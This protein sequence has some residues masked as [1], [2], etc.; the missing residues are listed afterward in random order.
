M[1]DLSLFRRFSFH[2]FCIFYCV[3]IV[4]VFLLC[5]F[6]D[7]HIIQQRNI[8]SFASFNTFSNWL[9]VYMFVCLFVCCVGGCHTG[10]FTGAC[11]CIL[12]ICVLVLQLTSASHCWNSGRDGMSNFPI[13][14]WTTAPLHHCVVLKE[15]WH[16]PDHSWAVLQLQLHQKISCSCWCW[17]EAAWRRSH[18]LEAAFSLH[19]VNNKVKTR[20]NLVQLRPGRPHET[21]SGLL[22]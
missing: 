2:S 9:S 10:C 4:F 11:Q 13:T 14:Q 21:R 16:P 3:C 18:H 7:V 17:W 8:R 19:K 22:I 20:S 12:C 15:N 6:Y 1:F 5:L